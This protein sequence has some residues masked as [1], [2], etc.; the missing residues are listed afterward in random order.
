MPSKISR[1]CSGMLWP[2]CK[3]SSYPMK[4]LLPRIRQ[5]LFRSGSTVCKSSSC[6]RSSR[7][8]LSNRDMVGVVK[9]I[10]HSAIVSC[11]FGGTV[12]A[13]GS[14]VCFKAY[15][16]SVA[17]YVL[18]S[19]THIAPTLAQAKNSAIYRSQLPLIIPTRSLGRTPYFSKALASRFDSFHSLWYVHRAPVH[20]I[21]TASLCGYCSTCW[22]RSCDRVI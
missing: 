15:S 4:P 7:G 22:Y 3:N 18:L 9:R 2:S 19:V 10:V 1:M 20:G 16:I 11:M 6:S 8:P 5:T 21:T 12:S 13:F 14:L 17:V